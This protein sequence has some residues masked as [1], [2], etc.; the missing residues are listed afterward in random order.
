MTHT[1]NATLDDELAA[2]WKRATEGENQAGALQVALAL[3]C[4]VREALQ[5]RSAVTFRFEKIE[6]G[7]SLKPVLA[8]PDFDVE[9]TF[10][11][12][13]VADEFLEVLRQLRPNQES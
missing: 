13:H 9:S 6:G 5:V 8:P 10:A 11:V 7:V 2:R 4:F 1:L 12:T 3:Y